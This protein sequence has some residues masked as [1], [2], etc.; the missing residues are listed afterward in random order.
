M[1][2]SRYLTFLI[3]F[4][5][6]SACSSAHSDQQTPESSNPN[7]L[8]DFAKANC[9]YWYFKKMNYDLKDI[10]AITGGIV[11]LGNYSIDTYQNV[12]LLIKKHKPSLSSKQNIDVDLWKCF[13]LDSDK[14][15]LEKLN[16]LK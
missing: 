2:N 7:E 4:L 8:L 1:T 13:R 12:S 6:S 11:E 14:V 5:L 9:M 16:K 3:A 15:F 10:S